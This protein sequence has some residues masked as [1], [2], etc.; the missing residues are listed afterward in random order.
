MILK[1][2]DREIELVYRTR[3][4][5]KLSEQFSKKNFDELFFKAVNDND[6][7]ALAEMIKE[8]AEEHEKP[9]FL[10]NIDKIYD[11]IDDWKKE[12]QKT[13]RDLFV[14]LAEDI[15]EQGFFIET[16]TEEIL[17]SKMNNPMSSIDMTEIIKET[18]NKVA[19]EVAKNDFLGFQ[20]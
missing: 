12:N 13:Y 6:I 14:A 17:K 8:F 15:N 18:T 20:A 5:A 10:G 3:K 1:A 2:K 16:M 11:F 7:K 19:L 9:A 4:I